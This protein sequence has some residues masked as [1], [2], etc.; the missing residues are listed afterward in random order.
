MKPIS[1][2]V[3]LVTLVASPALA[4]K[5]TNLDSVP[6]R[7]ELTGRGAPEVRVIEPNAT[8]YYSGGSQGFLA[9][10]DEPAPAK[11]KKPAKSMKQKD[12]VVHADGLLSG[13]IGNERTSG[14]PAD[15]DSSYVIWPGG[16]LRV[17]GRLKMNDR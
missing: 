8:E 13:I 16:N 3:L 1:F 12:S 11:G 2:A 6:H 15:T 9:L 5:I 4:M 7:V 14:I 10:V 17:Q